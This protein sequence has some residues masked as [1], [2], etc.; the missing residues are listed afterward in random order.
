MA[1]DIKVLVC[2]AAGK[3]GQAVV[4]AI[5]AEA[6]FKLVGAVVRSDSN[7]VNKDIGTICGIGDIGI[8][9]ISSLKEALAKTNPHVLVDFTM[10]EFVYVNAEMALKTGVRAIIGT[11]GMTQDDINELGKIAKQNA[12]GAIVAPNFAIGAILMMRFSKEASKYFS[13][14]EIIEMHDSKKVD[15]PSGTS[16][17]TAELMASA[18]KEFNGTTLKGKEII[19]GGRGATTIGN[20]N[21]HSIRLPA[22]IAHQEVILSGIGQT[23]TIRHDTY[24][25]TAFMPGVLMAIKKVME[26]DHLVYGLENI[27]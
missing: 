8:K 22:L 19:K 4:R 7:D 12:T 10:P 9:T 2:G 16:I 5:Y 11:T 26:L 1:K 20:I 25:R 6:G 27:I 23:L 17:K 24:D 3:M 18:R 21:I 14:A 13:N 15:S